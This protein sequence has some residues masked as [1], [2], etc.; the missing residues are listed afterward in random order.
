MHKVVEA[1]NKVSMGGPVNIVEY[2]SDQYFVLSG[3]L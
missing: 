2:I 3:K 1:A